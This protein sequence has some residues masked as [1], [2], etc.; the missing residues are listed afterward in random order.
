MEKET[1]LS[2]SNLIDIWA[3]NNLSFLSENEMINESKAFSKSKARRF[4]VDQLSEA[5][6]GILL[7]EIEK[8]LDSEL[9]R[10]GPERIGDW[11]NGWNENFTEFENSNNVE[12]L[13]PKYFGKHNIVRLENDFYKFKGTNPEPTLLAFLVDLVVEFILKDFDVD[14]ILEFGCGTGHHLIRLRSDYP[15][16]NLF[17]LDWAKS[18][19][20]IL[21]KFAKD[22]RDS[23]FHSANFD[24]F[25]P[26]A[27]FLVPKNSMV[28]T[29]ASLE[30]VGKDHSLFIDYLISNQPEVVV[31]IEPIGE[32]L[33]VDNK[34]EKLSID[35][36]KKRNYLNGYLE[37]LRER[38]KLGSVEIL[39][40]ERT[41]FGSMFIEGYSLLVWRP[42]Y[43]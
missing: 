10:S 35:Y 42:K 25:S 26:D 12:D 34:M 18:S 8:I 43:D 33:S 29:V 22:N 37:S 16:M 32:L 28:L 6:K 41:F 11:E 31:N 9:T 38:E 24:Y 20:D 19:Q 40:A 23:I 27:S 7:L 3:R 39:V 21:E 2:V 36:F 15:R 14:N 13:S 1:M 30:Q 17:G 5:N 4:S